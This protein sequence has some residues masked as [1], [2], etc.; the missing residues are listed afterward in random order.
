MLPLQQRVQQMKHDHGHDRGCGHSDNLG[1][2]NRQEKGS[3]HQFAM[4]NLLTA[5][6]LYFCR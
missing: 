6:A 3:T 5:K 2:G 4:A 1:G